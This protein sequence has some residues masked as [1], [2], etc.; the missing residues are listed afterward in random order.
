MSKLYEDLCIR[1]GGMMPNENLSYISGCAYILLEFINSH[2]ETLERRRR[3]F[4]EGKSLAR[5]RDMQRALSQ[6]GMDGGSCI[7]DRFDD[8]LAA[9]KEEK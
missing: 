7:S 9:E 5:K 6:H 4:E 2:P 3:D 1:M 8:Y